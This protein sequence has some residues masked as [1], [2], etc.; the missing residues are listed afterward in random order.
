MPEINLLKFSG[1]NLTFQS[2]SKR[3]G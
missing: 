2:E 3:E 1:L